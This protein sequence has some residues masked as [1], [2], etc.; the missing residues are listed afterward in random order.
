MVKII[1]ILALLQYISN[2]LFGYKLNILS[3]GIFGQATNTPVKLDVSSVNILGIYNIERGKQS[4][5]LTWDG[6]IQHGIDKDKLYSDFIKNRNI[7]PKYFPTMFGHTRQS[8]Y[9]NIVNLDNAHPFGYGISADNI[10]ADF[11]A[12]IKRSRDV[13]DGM[14]KGIQF[15]MKK[16]KIDVI[17]GT[18]TVKAGKK[19]EVKDFLIN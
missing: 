14:S 10:K 17:M 12:V 11:G 13:A 18:A 9:G 8:S 1:L 2:F 6:D 19:V 7:K 4:C 5:G 15:L 3:C 16:N